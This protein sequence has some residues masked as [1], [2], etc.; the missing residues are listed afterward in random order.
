MTIRGAMIF[1]TAVFCLLG[2]GP[3]AAGGFYVQAHGGV[4]SLNL[5]DVNDAV[6][7]VN[8]EVGTEAMDNLRWGPEAGLAFGYVLSREL[9]LGLGYAR[10][11][12]ASGIS[13]DGYLVR[14]DLPAGGNFAIVVYDV[15]GRRV[16]SFHGA[17][18]AGANT[19][20]WDGRD[21]GGAHVG[22]GVYYYRLDSDA[23]SATRKM[24]LVK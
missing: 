17:G 8:A 23:G 6:D 24:V 20:S 21:D 11:F 15:S 9:G 22:S 14:F 13:Q 5:D 7:R 3:A 4:T 1:Q 12:A 2:S 19:V 18:S 16:R 10:L